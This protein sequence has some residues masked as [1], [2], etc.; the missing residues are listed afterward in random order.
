[1]A[2]DTSRQRATVPT[3]EKL[4]GC[5]RRCGRH[6]GAGVRGKGQLADGFI[7]VG[8]GNRKPSIRQAGACGNV[9]AGI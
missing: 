3:V 1:M 8:A 2:P 6:R 4:G 5:W 9:V 7:Q